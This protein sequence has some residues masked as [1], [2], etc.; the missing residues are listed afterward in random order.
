MGWLAAIWWG[1]W[2]TIAV[3]FEEHKLARRS[4][5]FWAMVILT[6]VI[7]RVTRPEVLTELGGA[8]AAT[9]VTAIV[10]IL[11]TVLAF[12]VKGREREDR[13]RGHH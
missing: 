8:A 10:G 6:I 4:L 3:L 13:D 7:L 1:L 5:L 9:I 12:Y 11:T 2:A